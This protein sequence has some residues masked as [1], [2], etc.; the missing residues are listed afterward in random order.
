MGSHSCVFGKRFLGQ[1]LSPDDPPPWN[2]RGDLPNWGWK[3]TRGGPLGRAG[4]HPVFGVDRLSPPRKWPT[5][6]GFRL[7]H[8]SEADTPSSQNWARS[9]RGPSL[10]GR[11]V[12]I[13]APSEGCP[14][15]RA[16]SCQA[17]N[18]LNQTRTVTRI[19]SRG[20]TW[21]RKQTRA[22]VNSHGD[23]CL[24]RCG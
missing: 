4:L 17:H 21:L 12:G 20:Q 2:K 8:L 6:G 7:G 11:G 18:V 19:L 24:T 9:V 23:P 1:P 14:P 13:P 3:D 15:P 22:R 10:G 16:A 5:A